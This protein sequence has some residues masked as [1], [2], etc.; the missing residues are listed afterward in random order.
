MCPLRMLRPTRPMP[1]P[2]PS[3]FRVRT[4]HALAVPRLEVAVRTSQALVDR[5]GPHWTTLDGVGG[6]TCAI[7]GGGCQ[8]ARSDSV[9]AMFPSAPALG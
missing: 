2:G 6:K 4:T 9:D 8:H 3:F 5:T 1:C 7:M